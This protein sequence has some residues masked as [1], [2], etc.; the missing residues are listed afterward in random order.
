MASVS[1][2]PCRATPCIPSTPFVHHPSSI[3]VTFKVAQLVNSF[4]KRIKTRVLSRTSSI[5]VQSK[6][7]DKFCKEFEHQ[8][9]DEIDKYL[10]RK[11]VRDKAKDTSCT[12]NGYK[13]VAKECV[14]EN[15]YEPLQSWHVSFTRYDQAS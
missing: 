11:S 13:A 10:G 14:E 15:A 2:N 9:F 7:Q 4:C 1:A 5:K 8:A 12:R 3:F 6:V